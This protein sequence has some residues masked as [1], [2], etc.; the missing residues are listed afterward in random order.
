[1]VLKLSD[2]TSAA[3][4]R[5]IRPKDLQAAC[6]LPV[7]LTDDGIRCGYCD[8]L[9]L[10]ASDRGGT[11]YV[12]NAEHLGDAILRHAL[13]RHRQMGPDDDRPE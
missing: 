7:L 1:M 8:F 3:L 5:A 9:C 13:V 10:A 6:R 11:Y 2:A 12:Y 4:L